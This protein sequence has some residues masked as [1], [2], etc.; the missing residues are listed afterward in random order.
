MFLNLVQMIMLILAFSPNSPITPP[1]YTLA[2]F[3]LWYTFE[4]VNRAKILGSQSTKGYIHHLFVNSER[5]RYVLMHKVDA[6]L[7]AVSLFC[8]VLGLITSSSYRSLD[9]LAN[10]SVWRVFVIHPSFRNIL[11]VCSQGV[12]PLRMFMFLA[13]IVYFYFS[14]IFYE[15]CHGKTTDHNFD[16][17]H[18][19]AITMYQVLVGI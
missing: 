12:A 18:E 16:S 7:T 1:R 2:V 8:T 9:L 15:L 3:P 17:L 6:T 13:A 5:P 11:F 10:A 19:T 14:L 4:L